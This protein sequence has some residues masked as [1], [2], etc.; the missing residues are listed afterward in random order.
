[1]IMLVGQNII[2]HFYIYIK[3]KILKEILM[4]EQRLIKYINEN[5]LTHW[6]NSIGGSRSTFF[7]KALQTNPNILTQG[8]NHE[9]GRTIMGMACHYSV[10]VKCNA[11]GIFL[12][13]NTLESML[14]S[15]LRRNLGLARNNFSKMKPDNLK[16]QFS[17]ENWIDLAEQHIINWTQTAPIDVFVVNTDTISDNL[18]ELTEAFSVDFSSYKKGSDRAI[19]DDLSQYQDKL[20]SVNSRIEKLPNFAL[21]KAKH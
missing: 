20:N 15:Q 18:K 5:N 8:I 4:N 16:L 17:I 11:V 1:M 14:Q 19:S 21:I 7:R 13:R 2:F 12:Y 10:P 6:V 3:Y 9:H